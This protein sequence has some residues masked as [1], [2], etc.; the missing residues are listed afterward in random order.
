MIFSKKNVNANSTI[1]IM[2]AVIFL[3]VGIITGFLASNILKK[4]PSSTVKIPKGAEDTFEAGWRAAR[5]KI[6]SSNLIPVFKGGTKSLKGSI[7]EILE[8]KIIISAELIN[9]LDDEKLAKRTV[10][11]GENTKIIMRTE[12]SREDI[13]KEHEEYN[14]KM[15]EFRE[16]S[17]EIPPAPEIFEEKEV[18]I[19]GLSVSQ[20]LTV[21][22]DENIRDL[23]EFTAS[24][25]TV[26]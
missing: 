7:A 21:E 2:I 5:D 10:M 8:N 17:G 9:P 19:S 4:E 18:A 16:G 14:I 3:I 24:K 13:R 11:V 6:E 26:R 20:L 15:Q 23:Q 1:F 22:S 12:K 25:I